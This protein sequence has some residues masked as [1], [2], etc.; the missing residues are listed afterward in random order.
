M[1]HCEGKPVVTD[2]LPLNF[3]FAGLLATALPEA[4]FVHVKRDAAAVCWANYKTYFAS[5]SLG[6]C[7]GLGDVVRYHGLYENLMEF[8]ARKL[9]GRIYNL[10]YE[11]LTNDQEHETLKLID[12]IEL[13]WD[14][15]CLS[16]QNNAR[17]VAT[18]SS[19][20]VRRK[21]YQGSSEQWKKYKPFLGNA[22]DDLTSY[23]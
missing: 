17:A 15:H 12:Y 11:I 14:E 23:D 7:Y 20:Q 10:D 2:K 19:L 1:L 8:W 21:V 3:R 9:K 18:T 6:F 16:P 4:K 22:F 13:D 5:T